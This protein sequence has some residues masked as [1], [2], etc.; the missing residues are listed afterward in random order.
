M[1]NI[2]LDISIYDIQ[3]FSKSVMYLIIIFNLYTFII[4]NCLGF[5]VGHVFFLIST[6]V[7][8]FTLKSWYYYC[9]SIFHP[10]RDR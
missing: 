1:N 3:L 4:L 10:R 2:P 9:L 7:T 6:H 8:W 5:F